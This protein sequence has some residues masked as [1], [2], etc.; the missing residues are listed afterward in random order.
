MQKKIAYWDN[1]VDGVGSAVTEETDL[2]F[3]DQVDSL[4]G[5]Y[6]LVDT[7][8]RTDGKLDSDTLLSIR[9]VDTKYG[10]VSAVSEKTITIDGTTYPFG[11][12]I[13]TSGLLPAA[14]ND[15]VVYHL[16][17]NTL[18]GLEILQEQKA[19]LTYWNTDSRALTF[20][21]GSGTTK[22][23]VEA[24]LSDMATEETL[25]F[26]GQQVIPMRWYTIKR[27]R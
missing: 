21:Q 11:Q 4:V 5:H 14:E 19:T 18:V 6:V 16:C 8:A 10:E 27:I 23:T 9:P 3:L 13:D 12:N 24:A 15:S 26:L 7:K 20:S 1:N 2:S 17:G 25:E 22:T